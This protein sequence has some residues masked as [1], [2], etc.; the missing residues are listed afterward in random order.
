MAPN[1][2]LKRGCSQILLTGYVPVCYTNSDLT[3]TNLIV[4]LQELIQLPDTNKYLSIV[5]A[6]YAVANSERRVVS[7]Y[8][9]ICL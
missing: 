7:L 2:G 1:D 5:T 6:I 4:L 9:C 3:P 8:E